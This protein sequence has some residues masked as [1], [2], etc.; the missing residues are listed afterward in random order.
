MDL[1]RLNLYVHLESFKMESLH[2]IIQMVQPGDWMVSVDL[3]DAC[4][5]V[6][7]L[8]AFQ[9]YLRVAVG[10][11]HLQFQCLPFGL[12][13][14]PRIFS[15][16]LIAILA[17]LR[18]RGLRVFHFLDDILLLASSPA[19]L[20]EHREVLLSTL[21]K[22][23][24]LVNSE[25]SPD[26]N[27]GNDLFWRPF[28]HLSRN[29][30]PSSPESGGYCPEDVLCKNTV[31]PVSIKLYE[32]NRDYV[33]LY[34]D[35]TLG[36]LASED[37]SGG[38][39]GSVE[40]EVTMPA[41][42]DL[43]IHEERS[44]LVVEKGSNLKT[45]SSSMSILDHPNHR[46]K[47]VG[48]GR[49]LRSPCNTGEMGLPNIGNSLQHLRVKS[50][51]SSPGESERS[52]STEVGLNTPRQQG[53]SGVYSKVGG[54]PQHTFAERSIAHY[55]VGREESA[56]S[57]GGLPAGP[58]KQRGRSS[59]SLFSRRQ[60]MASSPGSLRLDL[61][62]TESSR[63]R[64]VCLGNKCQTTTISFS[65]TSSSGG[66]SGCPLESMELQDSICLPS[67]AHDLEVSAQIVERTSKGGN[68]STILAE[69]AMVSLGNIPQYVSASQDSNSTSTS[70]TREIRASSP[71]QTESACLDVEREGF[72]S[73][74][75]SS[76][77]ISTLL[78]ARKPSKIMCLQ[79]SGINSS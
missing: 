34:P 65:P 78:K 38:L 2:T 22:F 44:P 27:P 10:P 3:Q 4:F 24:W 47:L 30:M 15:K 77:V 75:C 56:G 28:R 67:Q 33:I 61:E 55:V 20:L 51:L 8:P 74:G 17:P 40:E 21:K 73:F 45:L 57:E 59:V 19:Q 11:M 71:S 36:S 69:E 29:S 64:P 58:S 13:T 31:S 37:F 39:S 49:T 63:D 53:S 60:R 12:C 79:R 48:L 46:C 25:K 32:S 50:S 54:D 6:P 62:S 52:S 14:S 66:S 18:E 70:L 7:I 42:L 68:D 26:S 35:A 16:V 41:D 23:G 1:K 5:H 72:Q 43:S 76:S 9:K